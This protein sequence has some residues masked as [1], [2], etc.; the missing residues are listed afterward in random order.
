MYDLVHFFAVYLPYC[1]Q[2]YLVS[3]P[4]HKLFPLGNNLFPRQHLKMVSSYRNLICSLAVFTQGSQLGK[5]V[6]SGLSIFIT[7][8]IQNNFVELNL[9][10]DENWQSLVHVFSRARPFRILLRRKQNTY[11]RITVAWRKW[12]E[13]QSNGKKI[14]SLLPTPPL[15]TTT[16]NCQ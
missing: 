10:R 14:R 9:T 8:E 7:R 2:C 11:Y 12:Y 1:S 3:M 16:A 6:N 4:G 15:H 5:N 13:T